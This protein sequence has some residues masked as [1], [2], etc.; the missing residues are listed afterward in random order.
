MKRTGTVV[1][2]KGGLFVRYDKH[3]ECKGCGACDEDR[4]LMLSG[5]FEEGARVEVEIPDSRIIPATALAYIF[6]LA[7]M[8]AGLAI[9]Y[10]GGSES[11]SAVS[12]IVCALLAYAVLRLCR[13]R[14]KRFCGT[15][16]VTV[17]DDDKERGNSN[18]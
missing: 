10:M 5:G 1:A 17:L 8:L 16:I 13:D 14:I 18:G 15:E 11:W 3:E 2:E 6:P 9:G 4:K 7:G 12:G